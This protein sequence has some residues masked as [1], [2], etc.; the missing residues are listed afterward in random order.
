M[1][2][3]ARKKEPTA[4]YHIMSR[5][6]TEFDL[7]PSNSDK[8]KFL[9]ILKECLVKFHCKLYCY[10]LMSNHYHLILDTCG[11]DISKFMKVLNQR[12]V[13]YIKY[14]Y[15]RKG[16][17]LAERF[18]SK[19][20]NSDQYLMA[21]SAYIHNNAKDI[22]EYNGRE[23]DYPYSSMGIYIGKRKDKI[24][25]VDTDF[26]LGC[27]DETNKDKALK[28]YSDMVIEMRDLGISNKLKQYLAEFKN[29]QYEYKSY[30]QVILR[31]KRP[32]EFVKI[33]AEKLGI[34]NET[35]MMHR[36]KRKTMNFRGVLAYTLNVFCGMNISEVCKFM[37]NITASCCS[38]LRDK[39]FEIICRDKEMRLHILGI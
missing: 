32:E 18:K 11:Y 24:G 35:Q 16:H 31:D 19:I 8:E 6:I 26:V 2:N 38:K 1:P 34:I 28:E 21:A 10:C 15:N 39:G 30:R 17:L 25:I 33:I 27:I 37:N 22:P 7:F 36:W 12:Y 4:V 20:I 9:Y 5:S 29:E 23:F 13:I 3:A 14:I